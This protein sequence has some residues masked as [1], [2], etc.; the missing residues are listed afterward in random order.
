M[1][2]QTANQM[3]PE[4]RFPEFSSEWQMKKLGDVVKFSRGNLLSKGDFKDDGQFK[5]IHYGQLFTQY[6]E[7]INEIKSRT[8]TDTGKRSVAGE[9]LMPTSDVTPQGLARAS[10]IHE[11]GVMIGGDINVLKPDQEI[12]SDF[13]SYLLNS[14]K[15]KIMRI[16]SGTTVRHVYASDLRKVNY[17]FPQKPE[18][19][20][21]AEFL[22]AVDARIAA[23]EQRFASLTQYKKAVMQQIFSQQIRFKKPDGSDYPDWE[24]K[25]LR[26]IVNFIQNGLSIDQ[27]SNKSGYKVTRIETISN[28]KI[29]ESKVGYIQTNKDISHY[30]LVQG[31]LLFSNINSPAHIGRTVFVDK[32]YDIYHGMNLLRIRIDKNNIDKFVYYT[33]S[34]TKYKQWFERICNKAVNQASIN[35][36]DLGKTKMSL[37]CIE[38]Q[39]KIADFLT[40]IDLRIEIEQTRLTAAKKWKKGLLQRMFV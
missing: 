4:L 18:Q 1:S 13:L 2:S 27:N 24:E 32:D 33:L 28:N 37:P 38:E 3:T 26:G 12:S 29:N 39:Q 19:E 14:Q 5:A 11:D 22:T 40:A 30:K 10:V 16:V 9:L 34:S 17:V 31:D 8:D 20:K 25:R 23:G 7:I 35:Q 6:N 15:K 36:T 21:I